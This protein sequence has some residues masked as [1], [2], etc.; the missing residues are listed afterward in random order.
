MKYLP[1]AGRNLFSPALRS[2]GEGLLRT[3]FGLMLK[4]RLGDLDESPFCSSSMYVVAIDSFRGA[5]VAMIAFG[6]KI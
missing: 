1:P 2:G 5:P 3:C 6:M 4:D